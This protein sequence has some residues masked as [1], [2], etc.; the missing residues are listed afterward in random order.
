MTQYEILLNCDVSEEE[1]PNFADPYYW[2]DYF[3]EKSQN[4]L[5]IF[6]AG[7]DH[8][9]SFITTSKNPYYDSFIEWQFNLL[10]EKGVIKFGKR[11][12]IYSTKDK[13][14]CA[15]HERAEGEGVGP[16]EYTLI[17]LE[18]IDE[19]KESV[20]GTQ[21]KVYLVPATLRPETMYG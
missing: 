13:E 8:R 6:G 9:R 14:I 11:P 21:E 12:S 15:D 20:F 19:K 17:K 1:L 7:I 2:L 3:P 18:V 16:Q 10:K 4:D 5:K